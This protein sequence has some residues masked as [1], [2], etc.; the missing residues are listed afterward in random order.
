MKILKDLNIDGKDL[1][2]IKNLYWEQKA[3]VRYENEIGRPVRVRRG[4]RQGC[5]LS[6]DLFSIYTEYIM[7]EIEGLPGIAVGGCM[8]NNLRYADDTVLIAKSNEDLQT[9][10]NI[11]N[12]ES[13]KVGLG[14]NIKKTVTMVI[15]KS[16]VAPACNISLNNTIL[17]Q[18]NSFKYLGAT[19]GSDGR[20]IKETKIR[21]GQAK[22]AFRDLEK[23]LKNIHI[24]IKT[25]KRVLDSYI[26]PILKYGS[27]AWT[28]NKKAIDTIEAAEMWFLRRMLRIPYTARVTN[29]E[30]LRR[31]QGNRKLANN[32][33]RSQAEF[34]G[35]VMRR[36]ALEHQITTG[37]IEGRRSRGRQR[38]KITDALSAWLQTSTLQMTQCVRDRRTFKTMVANAIG[39]GT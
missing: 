24:P 32:I 4:V 14:I 19:I 37:K 22:K 11:V 38:E 27:E 3:A 9:L 21:I 18:V 16:Q 7:R 35:H 6:P 34:F 10:L 1:R 36:E 33:R 26:T 23:I 12:R 13:E 5:V 2:L 39:P 15:S 28:L 29:I 17:D 20:S 30:V 25:R 31:A 8:I